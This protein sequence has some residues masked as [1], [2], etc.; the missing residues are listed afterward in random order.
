MTPEELRANIESNLKLM[1]A[2]AKAARAEESK[3]EADKKEE[4]DKKGAEKKAEHAKAHEKG[5]ELADKA[6][7]AVGALRDHVQASENDEAFS[8][9]HKGLVDKAHKAMRSAH[10]ALAGSEPKESDAKDE[11]AEDA[12]DGDK[13]MLATALKSI[14]SLTEKIK[15]LEQK[16]LAPRG[17]GAGAEG[18]QFEKGSEP[19]AKKSISELTDSER[20]VA[21]KAAL[22][23][24]HAMPIPA[25]T[26]DRTGNEVLKAIDALAQKI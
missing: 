6:H 23:R 16:V 11:D 20:E 24:S 25:N 13:A 22:G 15:G 5:A 9:E 2:A 17:A 14:G 10:K 19:T 21:I 4:E 12:E 18:I 8:D 3:E 26:F 1:G 7:K